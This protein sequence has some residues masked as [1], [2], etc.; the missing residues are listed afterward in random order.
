MQGNE[1]YALDFGSTDGSRSLIRQQTNILELE[2]H[3]KETKTGGEMLNNILRQ[4]DCR[5]LL[6]L[7]VDCL[8]ADDYIEKL[9]TVMD[10]NPQLDLARG[11]RTSSPG[12]EPARIAAAIT[13][14]HRLSLAGGLDPTPEAAGIIYRKKT[15]LEADGWH[16]SLTEAAQLELI[17]RLKNRGIK[18][19]TVAETSLLFQPPA[20]GKD[21]FAFHRRKGRE[22]GELAATDRLPSMNHWK[23]DRFFTLWSFALAWN[24]AGWGLAGLYFLLVFKI[25]ISSLFKN[26]ALWRT[27]YLLPL[28]HGASWWG[29]L[30]RRFTTGLKISAD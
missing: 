24:P 18:I 12:A 3:R 10:G 29:W 5:Y 11:K 6:C 4:T 23:A 17:N 27:I 22:L 16:E 15:V 20:K 7:E 9:S 13:S 21:F 2:I 1:F 8:P 28:L 19:Q 30:E 26:I 25:T 14:R